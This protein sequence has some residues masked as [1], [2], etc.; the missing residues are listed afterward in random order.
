[1]FREAARVEDPDGTLATRLHSATRTHSDRSI[2]STV[3]TATIAATIAAAIA[4]FRGG[5]G[6]AAV[7]IFLPDHAPHL[8]AR[9]RATVL[10]G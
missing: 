9:P 3:I 8:P 5:L 6:S 1:M 7:A 2:P 4:A 10:G